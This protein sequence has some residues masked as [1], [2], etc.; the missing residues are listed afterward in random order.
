MERVTVMPLAE[1]SLGRNLATPSQSS[2]VNG[3]LDYHPSESGFLT[4]KSLYNVLNY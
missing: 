2:S 3:Y 1:N 4:K